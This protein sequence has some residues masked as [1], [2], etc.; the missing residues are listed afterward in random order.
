MKPQSLATK[1]YALVGLFAAL[2]IA[3]GAFAFYTRNRVQI[4]S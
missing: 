4:G 3:F 1:L 2:L